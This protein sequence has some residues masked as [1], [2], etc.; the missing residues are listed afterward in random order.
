MSIF[1]F[2]LLK[3]YAVNMAC[4]VIRIAELLGDVRKAQAVKVSEIKNIREHTHAEPGD[5]FEYLRVKR[6]VLIE[7]GAE[8]FLHFHEVAEISCQ[9]IGIRR[10]LDAN[11]IV[12]RGFNPLG[13]APNRGNLVLKNL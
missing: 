7:L 1:V 3:S 12:F 11:L 13:F 8:L 4:V 2:E 10:G 5:L 9:R 6:K